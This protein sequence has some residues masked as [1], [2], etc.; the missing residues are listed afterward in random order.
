MCC[1]SPPIQKKCCNHNKN[2]WTDTWYH[3]NAN[4]WSCRFSLFIWMINE[5]FNNYL[6]DSKYTKCRKKRCE[7]WCIINQAIIWWSKIACSKHAD[8]KGQTHLVNP[9]NN[10]PAS[11]S[12]HFIFKNIFYFFIHQIVLFF[13]KYRISLF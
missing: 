8:N 5:I 11:I 13:H 7:R 1:H 3:P 12:R 2:N 9:T 6:I 4:S 10:H